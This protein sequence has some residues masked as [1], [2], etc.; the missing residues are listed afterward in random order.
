MST[1]SKSQNCI[2]WNVQFQFLK[3]EDF[4]FR[5][6]MPFLYAKHQ[7]GR[8]VSPNV[9]PLEFIGST[10]GAAGTLRNDSLILRGMNISKTENIP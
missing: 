7:S 2:R 9:L 5:H 1:M 4:I 10:I 3:H 6:L 8:S